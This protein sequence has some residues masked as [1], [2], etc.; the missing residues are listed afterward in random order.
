MEARSAHWKIRPTTAGSHGGHND[1]RAQDGHSWGNQM[2]R[3]RMVHRTQNHPQRWRVCQLRNGDGGQKVTNYRND[4][5]QEIDFEETTW[6]EQGA[7]RDYPTDVF[8]ADLDA[9]K[10]SWEARAICSKC[11]VKAECL[12]Y[13]I[14]H[15][16]EY[17]IWGG[18]T[19]TERRFLR[20]EWL[21]KNL[22]EQL[23]IANS[24]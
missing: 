6:A 17:G 3:V 16:C 9:P 2:P 11:P 20:S 12:D 8:F 7:C 22:K 5:G 14:R 13:A 21:R 24:N 1:Q 18:T 4:L 19:A 15:A 10:N 23:D